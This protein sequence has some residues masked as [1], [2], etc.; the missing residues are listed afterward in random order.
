[1]QPFVLRSYLVLFEHL[2][3]KAAQRFQELKVI[4]LFFNVDKFDLGVFQRCHV[5]VLFSF[6][7]F[8]LLIAQLWLPNLLY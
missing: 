2:L 6:L 7:F 5:T 8:K 4:H 3:E 1:M